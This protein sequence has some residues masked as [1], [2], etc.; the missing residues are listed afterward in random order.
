MRHGTQPP[1]DLS[2][3]DIGALATCALARPE[4]LLGPVEPAS[5]IGRAWCLTAVDTLVEQ[6]S[7][8]PW[9]FY[10]KHGGWRAK[11]MRKVAQ[12]AQ[13]FWK[14]IWYIISWLYI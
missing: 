7:V 2:H 5:A 14:V 4:P 3:W 11:R 8:V 6:S 9:C 12:T 13:T 10:R 1:G